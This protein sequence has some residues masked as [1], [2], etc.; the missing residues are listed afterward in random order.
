MVLPNTS[1]NQLCLIYLRNKIIRTKLEII[2]KRTNSKDWRCG[3]SDRA[4]TPVP[5]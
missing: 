3:S 5:P 2:F 1:L 4:Q